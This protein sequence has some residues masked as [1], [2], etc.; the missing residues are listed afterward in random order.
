L[1]AALGQIGLKEPSEARLLWIR[2]TL[3]LAEVEC[4]AAY[5]AEARQRP[6]LDVIVEPREI[7]LDAEGNLP[8]IAALGGRPVAAASA[9]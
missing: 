4:S 5:L 7:P 9:H 2:N 3:D 8:S 1:E 6:D